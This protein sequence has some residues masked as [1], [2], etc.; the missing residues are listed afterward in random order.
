MRKRIFHVIQIGDKEDVPSRIFDIFIVFVIVINLLVTFMSTFEEFKAWTGI[1]DGIELIS[2][3]I[4]TVEYI[5]RVWTADFLYPDMSGGLARLRFVF[6][7]YGIIDL[8]T[9][10]PYYIPIFVP[11][12]VVA[13]RMFR[14]I[15]IFR[16]FKINAQY[17]AFNVIV[18]VLKEKKNQIISS[19]CMIAILLLASSMCMYSIE[20]EAQPEN[21][22]NAFSGLWWSVST[23]LTV[24]YGDIY[25]VTIAG[26]FMAIVI[27]FLGVGMVAIP[28]GIISAGFVE[29]Y[30]KSK[31]SEIFGSE[32]EP[33]FTVTKIEKNH[34]WCG[35]KVINLDLP[36]EF[37]AVLVLRGEDELNVNSSLILRENDRLVLCERQ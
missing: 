27:S 31:N 16:L 3:I 9:F 28:T 29:Q 21:F 14:V 15:R 7:F 10:F 35:K 22:K 5:L 6:S 37:I 17:D 33:I 4:F 18:D 34:K 19:M 23:M 11:A 1:I 13:F 36:P 12:G 20:H 8:L 2:I 26:K 25:P 24:G 30:T 32:N